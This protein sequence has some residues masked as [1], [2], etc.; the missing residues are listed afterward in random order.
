M[1]YTRHPKGKH[2]PIR[3]IPKGENTL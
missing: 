1:I 3:Q 2:T